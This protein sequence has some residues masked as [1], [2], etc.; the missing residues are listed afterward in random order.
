MI[1]YCPNCPM[2]FDDEYRS[3][4]CPHHTFPANDGRNNFAHHPEALLTEKKM[5]EVLL[6]MARTAVEATSSIRTAAVSIGPKAVVPLPGPGDW[7]KHRPRPYLVS[8]VYDHYKGGKYLALGVAEQ[9]E[10]GERL[11][12]YVALTGAGLPGPRLRAR[13][14]SMWNEF[15]E[16]PDGFSKPRFWFCGDVDA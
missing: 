11:V 3:T 14:L 6:D 4:I 15:V 5:P 2:K 9:T 13:P 10:T 8:G 1:I 12:I 16:W 7:G